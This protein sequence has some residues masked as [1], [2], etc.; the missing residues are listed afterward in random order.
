MKSSHQPAQMDQPRDPLTVLLLDPDEDSRRRWRLALHASVGVTIVGETGLLGEAIHAAR[1][2]QPHLIILDPKLPEWNEATAI[3]A[4]KQWS[5]AST[6][7]VSSTPLS[8][9]PQGTWAPAGADYRFDKHRE[10]HKAMD[11]AADLRLAMRPL[12]VTRWPPASPPDDSPHP[13]QAHTQVYP[14]AGIRAIVA[15]R[16]AERGRAG[17]GRRLGQGTANDGD[18]YGIAFGSRRH[19]PG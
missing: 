11:V 3:L 19:P 12:V 8:S 18:A 2:T 6:I 1:H 9:D 14:D 16:L 17:A 15:P 10:F 7:L 5:P 4:L 13:W